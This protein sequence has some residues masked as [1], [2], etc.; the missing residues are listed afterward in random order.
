[1]ASRRRDK[2][3]GIDAEQIEQ[4][5]GSRGWQLI[6][7]RIEKTLAVKLAELEQPADQVVTAQIRGYIAGLRL[8][9][10]VPAILIREGEENAKRHEVS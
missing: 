1:M 4:T 2:L 9:L 7:Q 6:R 10:G 3:D 8:S 5:L